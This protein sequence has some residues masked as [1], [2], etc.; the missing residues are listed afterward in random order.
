MLTL[1]AQVKR[2]ATVCRTAEMEYR[3][4]LNAILAQMEREAGAAATPAEMLAVY[5]HG[6]SGRPTQ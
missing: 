4:A 3:R 2:A 5:A 1:D 6:Q